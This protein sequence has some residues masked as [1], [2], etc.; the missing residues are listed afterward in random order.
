MTR[1]LARELAPEGIVVNAVAPG[2]VL[3]EMVAAIW[4][5]RKEKYLARIPMQ[6]AGQPEEIA[7]TVVFLASEAAGYMT[8]AT[9]DVSGGMLMH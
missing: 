9:V 3:T 7:R 1:A 6:R 4:E 5:Q 8:G 2:M